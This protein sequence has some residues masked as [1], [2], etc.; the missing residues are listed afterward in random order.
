MWTADKD[1][2][3]YPP[4]WNTEG[5]AVPRRKKGSRTQSTKTHK[6]GND[7]IAPTYITV[8]L[9]NE[10]GIIPLLYTI[11]DLDGSEHLYM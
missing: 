5:D 3:I 1:A 10:Y 11:D 7:A 9:D 8:G 6:N 4:Y 2:V